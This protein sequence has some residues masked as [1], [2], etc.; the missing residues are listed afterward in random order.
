[1]II[2]KINC[3]SIFSP[4]SFLLHLCYNSVERW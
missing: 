1:M 4:L 2:P 3:F